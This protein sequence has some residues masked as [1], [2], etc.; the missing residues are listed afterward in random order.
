[1]DQRSAV[2]IGSPYSINTNTH[3]T[4]SGLLTRVVCLA[5]FAALA[6]LLYSPFSCLAVIL[7]LCFVLVKSR[8]TRWENRSCLLPQVRVA[9]WRERVY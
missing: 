8:K 2:D 3:A 9:P 4:S 1:M 5:G 6:S 7:G